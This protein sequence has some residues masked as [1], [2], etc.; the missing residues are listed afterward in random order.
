MQVAWGSFLWDGCELRRFLQLYRGDQCSCCRIGLGYLNSTGASR[1]GHL[2]SQ[3]AKVSGE[4]L[5]SF[6]AM[7]VEACVLALNR[8]QMQDGIDEV[9]LRPGQSTEDAR[10][11]QMLETSAALT[12][13][14]EIVLGAR[15]S[16]AVDCVVVAS[17]NLGSFGGCNP[18]LRYFV[19]RH[20]EG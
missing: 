13:V 19:W 1:F 18:Q 2:T 12:E 20:V 10:A 9:A 7:L 15:S 14:V 3:E 5:L 6:V 8:L 16:H 4:I 17:I 11:L